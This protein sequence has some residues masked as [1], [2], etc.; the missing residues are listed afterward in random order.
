[1]NRWQDRRVLVVGLGV[2]GVALARY[3]AVR[4][5]AVTVNDARPAE[6]LGARL[7]ELGG[8]PV[9]LAPGGHDPA[10]AADADAVYAS[11]GVPLDLPLLAEA[12]RRG[13]PVGSITTLFYEI[14]R[15]RVIGITGSAGKTTTT[16]LTSAIVA[17]SGRPH[18]LTGNIG[19]WPLAELEQ[20][21]PETLVIAEISHTQLQLTRRSPAIA[22]VT[23]VTPNHLDQF[24][25][26]AY[27][28]LKRN[29]VRHQS[30]DDIAVLNAD[31]PVGAG[32]AADT[33][34]RVRWFSLAAL[35]DG[36]DGAALRDGWV[37]SRLDGRETRVL[38]GADIP[39]RGRHNIANTLA[40]TALATAAGIEAELIAE[41][42]RGFRGVPHR[43]EVVATVDGVT[44]VN[45]SIATAPERTLAGMAAFS[46]PLVLLLG[47]RDKNLPLD[48]LARA[49]A[50]RCRA[51][52]TFGEAGDLFAAGLRAAWGEGGPPLRRV[53]TVDE[54]MDEAARL[55]QRG[56]VVLFSPAGTSFDAYPN[57]ERRGE[58]FRRLV[59]ERLGD[60]TNAHG[61]PARSL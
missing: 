51:V 57:F 19:V 36:A 16:A 25:W 45:D 42:V 24:D 10:L 50:E 49:A 31:D 6:A 52:V 55:A 30:P 43:L 21:A 14:C 11:Q 60:G 27:V 53:E 2:E 54:A 59:Y 7:A 56:D 15:G 26:P 29:H 23:N 13:V 3:F 35:P 61:R 18:V 48:G 17:A 8:V 40:A 1:M 32:F 33:P 58:S 47:G 5:A 34:A 28:D 44:W 41:A 4:G 22:C 20:V 46:E 39:L 9:T 37:V 38:P 12:R